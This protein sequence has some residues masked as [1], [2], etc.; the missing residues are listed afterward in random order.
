[1]TTENKVTLYFGAQGTCP[2]LFNNHQTLMNLLVFQ[3]EVDP[4]LYSAL[5]STGW[6]R[7]G[8]NIYRMECPSCELCIPLR[9]EPMS[10]QLTLSLNRIL[11]KNKD[12]VIIP[13]PPIFRAEHFMLWQRYSLWKHSI[14]LKDLAEDSYNNLLEPWSLIFEYRDNNEDR[15]LLAVSHVDPLDDGLSSV[16]FSFDPD[17]KGRSL[18]FYSILAESYLSSFVKNAKYLLPNKEIKGESVSYFYEN[19]ISCKLEPGYT[20]NQIAAI[21]YENEHYYY[22]GFWVP[23]APKMDYKARISPF[24]ISIADENIDNPNPW[25]RFFS[26]KEAITYLSRR[27]WP[28]LSLT[29]P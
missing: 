1:M 22:L 12:I 26:R 21:G 6:R 17:E 4:R 8:K 5:I 19:R 15:K 29:I 16:Y 9:L 24:E 7:H 18:G 28:G 20:K 27:E 10:I 25:K 3:D 2:Y 23:G 14:P 11:R 13:T